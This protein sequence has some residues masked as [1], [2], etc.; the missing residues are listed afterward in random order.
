MGSLTFAVT[1]TDDVNSS[2]L[3]SAGS[4]FVQAPGFGAGE[5]VRNKLIG[6]NDLNGAAPDGFVDVNWGVEWELDANTAAVGSGAGQNFDLYAALFHEFTHALGFGS[7]LSAANNTDRFGEGGSGTGT[8]GSW[9]K[10]DEFLTDMNGEALVNMI[11]GTINQ[12][13]FDSAQMTGGLFAG[14]E[15]V[16]AFGMPAQLFADPDQ[17]HLDETTFSVPS[18]ATNFMMKPNRDFGPL[19]ARTWSNLEVGILTDLGYSPVTAIP[20]PTSF[21]VLAI[22]VVAVIARRRVV[23]LYH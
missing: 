21:A 1:S 10:W 23:K 19:E 9:S 17:S 15:S 22:G 4:D 12:T 16:L 8:A 20:E 7:E 6:G 18:V 3:A 5:V 14:P 13:A 2:T 11:D